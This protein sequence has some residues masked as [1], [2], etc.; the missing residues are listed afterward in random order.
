MYA[1]AWVGVLT[2][3]SPSSVPWEGPATVSTPREHPPGTAGG[4]ENED[5]LR[6]HG[7]CGKDMG[8]KLKEER[9]PELDGPQQG[10]K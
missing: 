6:N 5:M 3:T 9:W 7:A 2:Y 1:D 4:A 10:N 8:A